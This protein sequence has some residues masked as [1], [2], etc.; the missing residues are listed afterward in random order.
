MENTRKKLFV[1]L[2]HSER[3]QGAV[4]IKSEVEWNRSIYPHFLQEIDQTYWEVILVPDTFTADLSSLN[5]VRRINWI[6]ARG[7]ERDFVLSI[8]GNA[9]NRP[10]VRG[11]A[12]CYKA[13][14][15]FAKLEAIKLS[16]AYSEATGVPLWSNGEFADTRSH[17]GR[18]GM[19]R[20]TK[21]FALL[22]EAGFVT[23]V[24][25]MSVNP[26]AAARGIANY[27]NLYNPNY[28]KPMSEQVQPDSE[29]EEA[30]KFLKSKGIMKSSLGMENTVT[31]REAALMLFRLAKYLESKMSSP[32][33]V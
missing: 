25:D 6:N 3:F 2:G 11:V 14:S 9:V 20:D 31:R 23:N 29:M 4:G 16:K 1:D 5:L 17:H 10:E 30:V 33:T 24:L 12:T 27:Y 22:I 7:N 15:E 18:L 19:V 28:K 21:P 8:H 32:N 26:V 13:G